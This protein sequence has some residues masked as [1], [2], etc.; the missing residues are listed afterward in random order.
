MGSSQA[1][2]IKGSMH[3][4]LEKMD[5][6]SGGDVTGSV[7]FYLHDTLPRCSL[8]LS[9]KGIEET[10]WEESSA[11]HTVDPESDP[12]EEYIQNYHDKKTIASIKHLLYEWKS[13]LSAGDYNIPFIFKLPDNLPGSFKYRKETT[14]AKIEYT[15]KSKLIITNGRKLFDKT[16][17]YINEKAE[18]CKKKQEINKS[19]GLKKWCCISQGKCTLN[20]KID[21]KIYN[22][23]EIVST[24][25]GADNSQSKIDISSLVCTLWR[26]LRLKAGKSSTFIKQRI[27]ETREGGLDFGKSLAGPYGIIMDLNLSSIK[28]K[29]GMIYSTKSAMIECSYIIEYH[30]DMN[31]WCTC[32][33]EK[34]SIEILIYLFPAESIQNDPSNFYSL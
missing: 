16:E 22:P 4:E 15:I 20:L 21:K 32:L 8:F 10:Y 18:I 31:G 9:F 5:C 27:T 11:S 2:A 24:V 14:W 1:R 13:S 17:M 28:H 6:N 3:I 33:G 12:E 26:V 23:D 29:T 19:F 30:A 25:V 34:P 7:H